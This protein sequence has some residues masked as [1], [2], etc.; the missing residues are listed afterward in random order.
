MTPQKGIP[1]CFE[2]E[3]SFM[4]ACIEA[5]QSPD[6]VVRMTARVVRSIMPALHRE[7]SVARLENREDRFVEA[8]TL[9]ISNMATMI[10]A[11]T[12]QGEAIQD[13]ADTVFITAWGQCKT[14]L[15][16]YLTID[17]G[18]TCRR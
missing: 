5:A 8:A 17:H 11:N 2:D 9:V 3:E 7:L 15:D 6:A 13:M 14:S 10:A 4:K 12:A 18:D 16:N 1:L